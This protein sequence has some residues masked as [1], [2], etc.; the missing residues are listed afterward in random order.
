MVKTYSAAKDGKKQ[1]TPHF[2][3]SEFACKDGTDKI[4]IDTTG[5]NKLELI[6]LWAG[7]SVSIN[8][9]Y[10]TADHN[11]DVGGSPTS[12]HMQGRAW[13]IIIKG[14]TPAQGA[15]FAQLIGF[16]GIEVNRDKNYL[17]VDTRTT[18]RLYWTH[19][20][21]KDITTSSF[22]GACPYKMPS[23]SLR[24]GSRG[25][26][27]KWLQFHLAVWGLYAGKID[28]SFGAQTEAAVKDFQA[29]TG[30]D[31]DGHVGPATRNKLR[32]AV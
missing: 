12:K 30:L 3:V 18:S 11:R 7:T 19:T 25:D 22:G 13:D 16:T 20:G 2:R 5:V 24:H 4:L 9:G 21:G 8:S 6:R 28:G 26:S 27:V 14:K 15:K 31:V 29:L 32:G 10:R 1:L 17:H 23:A